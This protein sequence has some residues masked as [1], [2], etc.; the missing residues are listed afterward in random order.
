MQL[1]SPHL[2]KLLN[3]ILQIIPQGYRTN[4]SLVKER[5]PSFLMLNWTTTFLC[6][7]LVNVLQKNKEITDYELLIANKREIGRQEKNRQTLGSLLC[8]TSINKLKL[9]TFIVGCIALK[10][11]RTRF[12]KNVDEIQ[13]SRECR[14]GLKYNFGSTRNTLEIEKI[15]F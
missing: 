12:N 2:E 3:M 10:I 4:F 13:N 5:R 6:L 9:Q 11:L 14:R 8:S 1:G 7:L 15:Y